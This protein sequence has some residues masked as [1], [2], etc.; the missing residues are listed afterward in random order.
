MPAGAFT[1]ARHFS[2]D[3]AVLDSGVGVQE[4]KVMRTGQEF[5]PQC[6][7]VNESNNDNENAAGYAR[8][9]GYLFGEN[10]SYVDDYIVD[11]RRPVGLAFRAIYSQGTTARGIKLLSEI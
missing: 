4:F 1:A 5:K 9:R 8:I 3:D 7:F 2:F 10:E 6:I 11:V